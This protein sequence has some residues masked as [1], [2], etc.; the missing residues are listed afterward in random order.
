M[1]DEANRYKGSLSLSQAVL[2][3]LSRVPVLDLKRKGGM[4]SFQTQYQ[5][6]LTFFLANEEHSLSHRPCPSLHQ[7]HHRLGR[8]NS[9]PTAEEMQ[10][11]MSCHGPPLF[12]IIHPVK[13][14]QLSPVRL[15]TTTLHRRET[16]EIL[17]FHRATPFRKLGLWPSHGHQK[18]AKTSNV[19]FHALLLDVVFRSQSGRK[20]RGTTTSPAAAKF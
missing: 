9:G 1:F 13:P 18:A 11:R 16:D 2:G 8:S 14:A 15:Y 7:V 4:S 20:S 5:S 12:I 6:S 19:P 10:R 17:D 3:R